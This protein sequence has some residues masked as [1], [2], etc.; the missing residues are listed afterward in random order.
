VN[1]RRWAAGVAL[2]AI[3]VA[4]TLFGAA[5]SP[6]PDR[7]AAEI[8]D[9]GFTLKDMNG[10]DVKLADFKGKPLIVNFWATWCGPCQIETPQLEALSRKY[11]AQG[12]TILGIETDAAAADV[13]KF[14]AEYKVTYPLLIGMDRTDVETAFDWTGMLPTSVFI[15]ADGAIVGRLQ[16]LQTDTEWDR[17]IRLLF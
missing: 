14:A 13:R 2:A 17:R 4:V 10:H 8:A 15:R 11:K 16:G 5:C 3:G 9:L 12:L 1:G 6:G 7:P